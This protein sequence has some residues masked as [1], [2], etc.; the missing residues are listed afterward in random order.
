MTI[1]TIFNQLTSGGAAGMWLM[2]LI[3]LMSLI[4]IS[5][6]KLNPWDS[7]FRWLGTKMNSETDKQLKKLQEQIRNMWI[8]SHRYSILRFAR[9]S[10]AGVEHSP[11]EWANL[12]NLCEEYEKYV[13]DN[14]ITN[15]IITQDTVYLRDLFQEL[16]REHKL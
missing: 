15:G 6:L 9:E 5:P 14:E 11:D 3:I 13:S 2:L 8:N 12:L 16:S 1:T 4:Q 7:V 10:R